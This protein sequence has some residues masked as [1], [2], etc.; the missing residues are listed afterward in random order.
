[1]NHETHI[2]KITV[3]SL[4]RRLGK[5]L[6]HIGL[7]V[8]EGVVEPDALQPV[9]L[10]I[11]PGEPDHV[12]AFDLGNLADQAAD[13]PCCPGH[14]HRL[15]GLWFADLEEA[16]VGSV[17]RHPTGSNQQALAQSTGQVRCR[18]D[19]AKSPPWRVF[20]HLIRVDDASLD[21][22]GHDDDGGANGEVGVLA[23]LHFGNAG[24]DHCERRSHPGDSDRESDG[25]EFSLKIYL[26]V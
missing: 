22:A 20:V 25:E 10:L 15:P 24:P 5:A 18:H 2:I 12:A 3:D 1:M 23:F 8:V 16:K 14:H 4:G 6:S 26:E 9:A 21:P 7:L 17:A 11:R 19:S 13:R